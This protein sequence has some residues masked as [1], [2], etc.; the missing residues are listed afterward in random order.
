MDF[1]DNNVPQY[2][3]ID[4]NKCPTVVQDVE[5]R[6]DCAYVETEGI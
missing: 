6:G 5:N 1:G 3:F 2:R 4:Y